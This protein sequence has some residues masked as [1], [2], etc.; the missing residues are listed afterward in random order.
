MDNRINYLIISIVIQLL[1]KTSL[2][3]Q[4]SYCSSSKSDTQLVI[5]PKADVFITVLLP[6]HESDSRGLY[7]CGR[8]TRDGVTI[9]EAIK[10]T[11]NIINQNEGVINKLRLLDRFIPG[12]RIGAKIYD[13]CGH[14]ESAI[15]ALLK[16]FPMVCN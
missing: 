8:I 15:N 6:V 11:L 3:R 9:Y 16:A 1:L 12:V 2:T 13:N 10:W 5:N 7:S 4:Q 14:Q